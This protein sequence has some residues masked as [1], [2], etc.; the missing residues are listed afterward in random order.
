MILGNI[1]LSMREFQE[2]NGI[3]KQCITNAQYLYDIIK[4]NTSNDVKVN[5]VIVVSVDEETNTYVIVGGHLVVVGDD[6]EK[7]IIDPSYETFCLKNKLYF[8]NIRDMLDIF[9]NKS[10]EKLN[11]KIDLKKVLQEHIKFMKFAEQINRGE[12]IITEKKFYNDQADY[13]DK[14]YSKI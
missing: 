9:D 5:A 3:T 1:I 7:T 11:T 6:D 13:I 4:M 14:L 10:K 2:K 8:D 12:C